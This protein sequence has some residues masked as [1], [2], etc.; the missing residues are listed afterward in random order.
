MAA[1]RVFVRKILR[2][3]FGPIRVRPRMN[4]EQYALYADIVI[5]QRIKQRRLRW[6]GHVVPNNS[7]QFRGESNLRE[8]QII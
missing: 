4:H 5:N 3:I 2:K 8:N 6:L 7:F 1:L